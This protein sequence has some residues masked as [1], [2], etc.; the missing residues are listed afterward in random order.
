MLRGPAHPENFRQ[1]VGRYGDRHYIDNLPGDGIHVP[2]NPQRPYP[3]VSVVKGAWPKF[4]TDWAA[5]AAAQYAV[6]HQDAWRQ[7]PT[8]DAIELITKAAVRTRDRAAKRGSD[9][10]DIVEHLALGHR[11]DYMLI[12]DSVQP[13]VPCLERMVRELRIRPVVSEAVV[14]NHA[15]GYGG[16]FDMI[17]ETVHGIGLL[18]WKTRKKTSR[19]DEEAAQVAAYAGGEY[20]IVESPLGGAMRAPLPSIDYL[21]TIVISPEGYQTHEIDEDGAWKLWTALHAFWMAKSNGHFWEG[22]LA[23]PATSPAATQANLVER[24]RALSDGARKYLAAQWP[25]GLPTLKQNPSDWELMRIDALVGEVEK[26]DSAPFNPVAMPDEGAVLDIGTYRHIEAV[27]KTLD[28]YIKAAVDYFLQ[29]ARPSVAMG[30]FSRTVRRFE[31][32]RMLIYVAEYYRGDVTEMTGV[33]DATK[34]G[35][36]SKDDA[37]ALANEYAERLA[38]GASSPHDSESETANT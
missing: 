2:E 21:A 28:D 26:R 35:Y 12:D 8:D 38:A 13:Y 29:A 31:V 36:I 11:P 7:L 32:L 17:A 37:A 30:Q 27:Y 22:T 33:I 34:L 16:T 24:V 20:M 23:S 10:H 4:L 19:Y 15:L 18:D 1:Q 25:S 3:S 5:G 14:F 6:E 9:V